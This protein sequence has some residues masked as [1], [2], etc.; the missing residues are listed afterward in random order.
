MIRRGHK[1]RKRRKIPAPSPRSNMCIEGAWQNGSKEARR[2]KVQSKT[3]NEGTEHGM[4]A[5]RKVPG[6]SK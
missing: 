3:I 6:K 2:Q 4:S 5:V 1:A